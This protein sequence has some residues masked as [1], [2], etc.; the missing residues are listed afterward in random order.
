MGSKLLS[1]VALGLLSLVSACSGGA[2]TAGSPTIG[3]SE[4]PAASTSE[5]AGSPAPAGGAGCPVGEYQVTKIT[6]K[7]GAQ[8][9]GVPVVAKSG[10]GFTLAL[11]A[12]GKWT[13]TGNN[14]TVTLEAAN[15]S[16]DAT[17]NGTAEGDYAKVGDKYA[18]RQGHATGKVTLKKAVAGVSSWPMD[19][20][21][22]AL[23]P[24]GQATITCGAGT[25]ALESE[26]VVLDLQSTGGGSSG[27][28][29][30]TTTGGGSGGSGGSSGAGSFTV[31]GSAQTKTVDCAGRNAAITGSSN[32]LTFTG[33]CG[34]VS[35]NGSNNTIKIAKV[36]Q[37]SV[38]GSFNKVTWSSGSPKTSNNGTGNT[39]SQG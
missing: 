6:G 23:A 37:I 35:V 3:A 17:I 10:G 8:V 26:S 21:G 19:Q 33:T 4:A 29:T 27:G 5:S 25:A 9:D 24:G 11:T 31:E 18:F 1:A 32:K 7:S 34:S 39:I 12:D 15:L 38:N 28:G 16:V 30:P 36:G 14:A 2:A 22:P 20:V 13:L